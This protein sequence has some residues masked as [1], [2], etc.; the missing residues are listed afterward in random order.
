[1]VTNMNYIYYGFLT[2]I[3][4]P[5]LIIIWLIQILYRLI[6]QKVHFDKE[7]GIYVRLKFDYWLLFFV[8]IIM[9]FSMAIVGIKENVLF[10]LIIIGLLLILLVGIILHFISNG[11]LKKISKQFNN[12]N[13]KKTKTIS[14]IIISV[15][16]VLLE[17]ASYVFWQISLH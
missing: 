11:T 5:I 8:L 3:L 4:L 12:L 6:D 15:D 17:F 2:L 13:S 1:M 10:S 16:L 9:I 14:S 7:G